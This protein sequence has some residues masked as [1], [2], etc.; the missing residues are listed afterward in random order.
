MTRFYQED[1]VDMVLLSD[2]SPEPTFLVALHGKPFAGWRQDDYAARGA[3]M[4][5]LAFLTSDLEAWAEK[6]QRPPFKVEEGH[7][8]CCWLREDSSST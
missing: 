2:R 6:L 3:Q 1:Q 4:S 7:I 5:A 8:A